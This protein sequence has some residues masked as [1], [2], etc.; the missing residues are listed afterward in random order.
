[1]LT[2]EGKAAGAG[3]LQGQI[4]K[5]CFRV[6]PGEGGRARQLWRAWQGLLD[7]PVTPQVISDFLNH[8]DVR[9][10]LLNKR[11]GERVVTS[12]ISRQ[13]IL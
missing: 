3:K 5:P 8:L 4:P 12:S 9:V 10:G 2:V 7:I 1:M 6:H 13:G 11:V